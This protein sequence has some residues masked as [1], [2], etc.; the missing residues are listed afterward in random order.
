[1]G[2]AVPY[3]IAAKLAYPHRP[4]VALAG[5][6]ALQMSGLAELITV[7]HRWRDW[8]TRASLYACSTTATWPR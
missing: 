6:G 3:G 2:S 7:A 8:A 5:D 4:L 1:M